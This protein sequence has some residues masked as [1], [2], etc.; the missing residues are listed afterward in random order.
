MQENDEHFMQQAIRLAAAIDPD[1][2][3][4]NPRVGCVIVAAGRV[5]ATGA[6]QYDGGPH[7]EA[8]AI[9]E[10]DIHHID[11]ATLYVTLEPC[12]TSGRT[13]ACTD[14]IIDAGVIKRVVI[15]SIDPNPL[16]RGKGVKVL[17]IASLQVDL[18]CLEIECESLNPDFNARMRG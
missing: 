16:H 5:V 3:K 7:A 11:D 18:G 15:G 4:P 9:N 1:R 2:T 17:R 6:H 10:L 12:S 8:V 13:G 14:R